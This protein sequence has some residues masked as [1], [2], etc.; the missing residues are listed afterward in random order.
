MT[1][2]IDILDITP[3]ELKARLDAGDVPVL[4]DVREHFERDIADL[5]EH[6]QL[7]IPTG[8]F[9]QRI[10]EIGPEDEV[11]LYCR[12][13]GRSEWAAKLLAQKGTSWKGAEPG[14][15]CAR[16]AAGSR[17]DTARLLMDL[18]M[19]DSMRQKLPI[20]SDPAPMGATPGGGPP[21]RGARL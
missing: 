16:L 3:L 11:V 15:R 19:T 13:G 18:R 2:P 17:P 7:R 21:G 10:G 12:S 14:G 4:V 8:E 9:M 5:P 6:G 1:D 20:A